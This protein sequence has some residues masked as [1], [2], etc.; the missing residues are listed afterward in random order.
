MAARRDAREPVSAIICAQL[1]AGLLLIPFPVLRV[2]PDNR[3]VTPMKQLI[4]SISVGFALMVASP[5]HAATGQLSAAAVPAAAAVTPSPLSIMTARARAIIAGERLEQ[6]SRGGGMR[7]R[8][9]GGTSGGRAIP[10]SGAP[11][12]RRFFVRPFFA[13]PFFFGGFGLGFAYDPFLWGWG[14]P[15][16]WGYP[17]WG[18]PYYGYGGYPGY[19][20]GYPG[21]GGYHR[22]GSVKLDVK[23]RNAEVY[24]DGYYMG[25][26][27]DFNGLGHH[28]D[29]DA[30]EHKIEIRAPGYQPL[31]LTLRVMPGRTVNYRGDL[32]RGSA[33]K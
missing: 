33:G 22:Y 15:F 16:G 27:R 19:G 8:G 5:L 26:V 14:Y 17:Y 9:G 32:R 13:S 4:L 25:Q 6:H 10:R 7:A 30:G 2:A 31:D 18:S 28:L 29:V 21:R 11:F 12:G 24:V 20:Y 23:P 3:G 1:L